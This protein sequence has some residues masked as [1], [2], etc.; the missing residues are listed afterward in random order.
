M[1]VF[2]NWLQMRTLAVSVAYLIY[3]LVC[4]QFNKDI[5]IDNA[6]HHLVSIVGLCAGLAYQRVLEYFALSLHSPCL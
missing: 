6:I 3:D 5:K 1:N 4:S 2:G